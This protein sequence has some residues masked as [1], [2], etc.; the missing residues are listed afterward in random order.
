MYVLCTSN[1][2][3]NGDEKIETK[4]AVQ[5]KMSTHSICVI[6]V[7]SVFPPIF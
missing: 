5:K 6:Y 2:M 1:V 4:N 7:Y 3:F